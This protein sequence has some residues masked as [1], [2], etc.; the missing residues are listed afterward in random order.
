MKNKIIISIIVILTIIC[1]LLIIVFPIN[2]TNK[3][4]PTT[5]NNNDA[6]EENNLIDETINEENIETDLN[7]EEE[8]D[9]MNNNDE[10]NEGQEKNVDN[11]INNNDIKQSTNNNTNNSEIKENQNNTNNDIK[12]N[13]NTIEQNTSNTNP[14]IEEKNIVQEYRQNIAKEVLSLVNQARTQNG[15]SPL[16][17]NTSLEEAAMIRSKELVN[18]FSHTRPDGSSCFTV[19]NINYYTAGENIAAG[20]YNAQAV[21]DSWMNSEGHRANILSENFTDIGISLYSDESSP[22]KYNWVQIFAGI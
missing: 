6:N 17:W 13:N 11:N 8:N 2:T 19:I 21:F 7:N 14:I 1:I 22:Y 15:L 5:I 3:M 16:N 18:N 12:D 9:V 20:Q 10:S 4:V